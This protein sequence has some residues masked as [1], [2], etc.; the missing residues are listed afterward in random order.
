MV[1][2]LLLLLFIVSGSWFHQVRDICLKYQIQHPLTFLNS[3]FSKEAFKNLVK[4]HVMNFWEKKLR[5]D[6]SPLLSLGYFKPQYM[7]LAKPHPLFSTAGASPYEVTKAGIQA[8]FLSGRY[9]TEMLSS[10]WSSNPGGFCL[11][12]S[13]DGLGVQEDL[14]HILLYCGSLSPTRRRLINFTINYA[15]T[16][17]A[18]SDTILDLTKPTQP[19]LLQFLLDCSVIPH[20]IS[21]VQVHGDDVLHHLFKVSR[22]WCYS[23]HKERLKILG[24]WT[25]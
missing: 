8:L 24:R 25:Q 18:L 20:V 16:V 7:S 2:Y 3:P 19:L 15:K 5:D 13:C 11:C 14:E 9:R 23:L 17:P 10:H 22:T 4:K 1:V 21:L 6:A 12:P